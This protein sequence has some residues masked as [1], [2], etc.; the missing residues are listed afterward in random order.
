MHV[1]GSRS[2]AR[3]LL[4]CSRCGR[5]LATGGRRCPFCGRTLATSWE[6]FHSRGTVRPGQAGPR[7]RPSNGAGSRAGRQSGRPPASAR[8][9]DGRQSVPLPPGRQV[10]VDRPA[11]AD[12][13]TRPLPR[14][15]A[16]RAGVTGVSGPSTLAERR[17][18]RLALVRTLPLARL[19]RRIGLTG[20]VAL[21]PT[22]AATPP[23]LPAWSRGRAR[24]EG[25]LWFAGT[26]ALLAVTA[27]L[28]LAALLS[29]GRLVWGAAP[30]PGPASSSVQGVG[31][32]SAPGLRL[33]RLD[34]GRLWPG[35]FLRLGGSGF[36]AFAPVRFWLDG[37]LVF[38]DERGWPLLVEAD[39]AGHFTATLHLL[40]SWPLGRHSLLARD[41]QTGAGTFLPLLL[42]LPPSADRQPQRLADSS[43]LAP[44]QRPAALAHRRGI[45]Q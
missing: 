7:R 28:A 1:F 29:A 38:V 2:G 27:A 8:T 6:N 44:G 37:S 22:A 32:T 5:A 35:A 23:S 19:G 34:G 12:W 3:R 31:L 43:S 45:I 16:G 17:R 41:L 14:L 30:A 4:Q 42:E 9:G 10:L 36:S 15:A 18:A 11:L 40:P 33:V 20:Q 25:L 21:P 39:G 13:P 24:R 26:L